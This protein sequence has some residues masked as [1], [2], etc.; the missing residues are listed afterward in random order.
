MYFLPEN[1]QVLPQYVHPSYFF[2]IVGYLNA[3]D[4]FMENILDA[5]FNDAMKDKPIII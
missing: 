4:M 5:Q 1:E 2:L 3:S